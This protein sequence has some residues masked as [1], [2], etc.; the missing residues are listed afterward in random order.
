MLK[1]CKYHYHF[2]LLF[3]FLSKKRKKN[4]ADSETIFCVSAQTC[5]KNSLKNLISGMTR[6]SFRLEVDT[7]FCF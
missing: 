7:L 3:F 1:D 4:P 2:L 6:L 5:L